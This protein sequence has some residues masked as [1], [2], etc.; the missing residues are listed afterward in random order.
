MENRAWK[1]DLTM[2]TIYIY[3]IVL[4]VDIGATGGEYLFM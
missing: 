1:H 4:Y 2:S 3:T